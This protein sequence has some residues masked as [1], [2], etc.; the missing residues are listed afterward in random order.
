MKRSKRRWRWL[1]DQTQR[2]SLRALRRLLRQVKLV[3]DK[4]AI[5]A[6][7]EDRAAQGKGHR[8]LR[9]LEYFP[10]RLVR[11]GNLRQ[12]R[13]HADGRAH[14]AGQGA[15]ARRP[16]HR[17]A[18]NTGLCDGRELFAGASRIILSLSTPD[19]RFPPKTVSLKG[20]PLMKETLESTPATAPPRRWRARL[21]SSS[22]PRH[23]GIVTAHIEAPKDKMLGG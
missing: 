23:A 9:E 4:A 18:R 10:F 2:R 7:R 13:D 12:C 16:A 1:K 20:R 5:P 19:Q 15:V 22:C 3:K 14:A 6:I 17:R 11:R 8:L 21:K